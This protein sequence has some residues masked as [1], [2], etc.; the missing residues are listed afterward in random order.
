M[1][2]TF[3]LD[4]EYVDKVLIETLKEDFNRIA[5]DIETLSAKDSLKGYQKE[6]LRNN[7]Q[8]HSALR[9]VLQYYMPREDYI[10]FILTH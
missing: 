5:E 9:I 3:E 6:D 2:M 10:N 1:K 7:I 8:Y 4:A